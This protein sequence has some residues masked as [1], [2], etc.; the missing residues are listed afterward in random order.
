MYQKYT[1]IWDSHIKKQVYY[2]CIMLDIYST[3]TK[4]RSTL[5]RQVYENTT[6]KNIIMVLTLMLMTKILSEWQR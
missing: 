3:G 4:F 1:Q 2:M 6:N 5:E